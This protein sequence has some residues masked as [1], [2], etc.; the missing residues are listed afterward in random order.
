VKKLGS[1]YFIY[2]VL[3]LIYVFKEKALAFHYTLIISAMMFFLCYLKM[4]I[5]F[6]RPY[7]YSEAIIPTSCSGQYGCPSA[8]SIRVATMIASLFLDFVHTKRNK[9]TLLQYSIGL[10]ITIISI[11]SVMISRVYLAAHSINQVVYGATIGLEIALFM[12]F[13]VKP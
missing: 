5:R 8:T 11:V 1:S 10:S 13:T 6:P 9:I 4:I 12:H 3:I 2:G 7:Q